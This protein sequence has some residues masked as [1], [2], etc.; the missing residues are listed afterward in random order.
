MESF[1][2]NNPLFESIGAKIQDAGNQ[3]IGLKYVDRTGLDAAKDMIRSEPLKTLEEYTGES[4]NNLNAE[5]PGLAAAYNALI[6]EINACEFS[7]ER[8]KEIIEQANRLLFDRS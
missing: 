8:L 1:E 2:S 3:I 6:A 7:S 5:K 4:A